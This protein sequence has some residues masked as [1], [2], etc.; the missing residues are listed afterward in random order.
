MLR[1]LDRLAHAHQ[2]INRS[3]LG[4]AAGYGTSWPIDRQFTA[5]LLGFDS[6]AHNSLD[7]VGT[8]WEAEAQLATAIV[9]FMDHA[10]QMAADLIF[11]ST[12]ESRMVR[13]PDE[14]V[15]GSSIMPQKRN[16]DFAEVIQA[17]AALA[18]GLLSSLLQ[19]S[20]GAPSGY[21]REYQWT[22]YIVMDVVRE[23]REVPA[24]LGG[25]IRKVEV[26][27]ERMAQSAREGFLNAVDVAE[28]IAQN[29]RMSFR[30]AHQVV[31]RAI[32]ECREAGELTLEALRK[33]LGAEKVRR[34]LTGK[35]FEYL[36][37]PVE[38]LKRRASVGS[39]NPKE[40]LAGVY[41]MQRDLRQRN[42][43]LRDVRSGV[44]TAR[45]NTENACRK[46]QAW[47]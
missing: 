43:W 1:D 17:K 11:L 41:R 5:N 4:A 6:V 40:L 8:R 15:T 2:M 47:R 32:G 28:F 36:V 31:A 44:A 27:R 18:N 45:H 30:Q 20:R 10:S 42:G 12:T 14:Y 19:L 34:E 33:S 13:I 16:P 22:K 35:D 29:F 23:A 21:N 9:F 3:P 7:A 26:D 39:P 37:S 38:N 24:I 46:L 25:V